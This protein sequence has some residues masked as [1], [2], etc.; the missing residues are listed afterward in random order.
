MGDGVV[1]V[2]EMTTYLCRARGKGAKAEVEII[3]DSP[4]HAAQEYVDTEHLDDREPRWIEVYVR[5]KDASP[6]E[7]QL[8]RIAFKPWEVAFVHCDRPFAPGCWHVRFPSGR[9]IGP[10]S[11]PGPGPCGLD[12]DPAGSLGTYFILKSGW[13]FGGDDKDSTLPSREGGGLR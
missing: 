8:F 12:P 6:K 4:L 9:E 10:P 3:T 7:V 2:A 1:D 5:R 11:S 13:D